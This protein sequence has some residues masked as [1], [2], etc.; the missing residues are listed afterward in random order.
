MKL[1]RRSFLAG[2]AAAAGAAALPDAR[3]EAAPDPGSYATLIDLSRCDGCEAKGGPRCV[4]ACRE[5]N[6]EKFPKPDPTKIKDYWPQKMHED[7]SEKQHL[8]DRL[9]PYNWL[10]V[11]TVEVAAEGG[12]RRLSIP[13]RC[14]HCDNPACAKLCPFGSAKKTA[15]GPVHIDP[16]L[17]FGGAKCRDVC[18]WKVP[19][20]QAG[21]GVYTHLEPLPV[22]GGVMYK[23]DLCRDRL[24][25][26]AKPACVE[27]CPKQA[28]RIGRRSDL[29]EEARA[30]AEESGGY[31]YGETENGGTSTFYVSPVPFEEI[32]RAIVEL[33]G[34]PAK[35]MRMHQPENMLDRNRGLAAL[36]LAAP[37][38]GIAG[39]LVATIARKDKAE[40]ER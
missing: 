16:A 9:T 33:A 35:A 5:A 14:M 34:D 24:G 30:L 19:Q 36:A 12:L 22:G 6:A 40:G 17:C 32:D 2:M 11:Q 21:V 26:G 28:L 37:I 23:C 13:R 1:S 29:L 7:W 39:A 8:T 20:R 4:L 25:R 3:A 27:A 18:P 10:F 38:V 15:E 31:L